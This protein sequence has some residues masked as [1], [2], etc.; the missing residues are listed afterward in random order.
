MA[1][2]SPA[3][4][5]LPSSD[6]LFCR[7]VNCE[8]R[9]SANLAYSSSSAVPLSGFTLGV[10]HL[11]LEQ[12]ELGGGRAEHLD[13]FLALKLELLEEAGNVLAVRVHALQHVRGT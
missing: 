7:T 6:M 2:A 1:G 12:V 9:V 10:P 13:A 5:F 11:L 3:P 4:M 8:F